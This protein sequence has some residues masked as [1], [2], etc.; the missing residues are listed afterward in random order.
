MFE[1]LGISLLLAALLTFNSLASLVTA[2]LW[3]LVGGITHGWSALSRG[4]LL[5]FLRTLPAIVAILCVVVLLTPAY[6]SY[7]PRHATENVS[8][9]LAFLAIVSAI[10]IGLAIAR[11][12]AAWRATARLTADWLQHGE[13]MTIP[14]VNIAAYRIEHAFPV[15]AIV[16][17][18]RPRLFIA[19]RIMDA[20]TA[21]E[22][23]AAVA[24]ENGHLAEHDNLKRGL[25]RAC[26]DA[27]LI[28]PCGRSLDRSWAEAS[29][30]AADEH[31]AIGG[32]NMALDLAS[33]LVKIARIV[34][35]GT[36]P[37]MPAGAFL[38]GG[39]ATGIKWRVKR[40]VQ[41]AA[42]EYLPELQPSLF[43]DIL[44]SV[45]IGSLLVVIPI[46]INTPP[47]LA[48][49]HSIIEHAVFILK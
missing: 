42:G 23:A 34:P 48:T 7:E 45:S 19:S 32:R 3:R 46:I 8:L 11:G 33:A 27:L 44:I 17:V 15:I 10:G 20:L 13:S 18:L 16:G 1:L 12:V 22:I 30:E 39:D 5:F 24:H 38:V 21:E 36:R 4:R 35:A 37:T 6:L 47:V 2:T 49:V 43:M 31:A 25:L 9:K 26:R 28:V 40:L 41:L 14:G 29:E